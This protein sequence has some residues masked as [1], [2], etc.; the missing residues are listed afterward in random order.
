MET[1]MHC[2]PCKRASLRMRA[3]RALAKGMGRASA[4][5]FCNIDEKTLVEWIKRFN[6]MGI[7]GFVDKPR[8]GAPRKTTSSQMDG[9]VPPLPNNPAGAGQTHW[10]A[11]KLH[12]HITRELQR[13]VSRP[14]LVRNLHEKGYALKT[15]GPAPEPPD[16]GTWQR[17][18][19]SFKGNLLGWTAD[20]GMQ[21]WFCDESGFEGDP[22]PRKRWVERG[23]KPRIPY[24]GNHLRRNVIGAVSPGTGE[25]SAII[26]NHCDTGV[27]QAF[28][29][30]MAPEYPR[31]ENRRQVIV[32]DNA[33]WHKAR[34]LNRHH[35]EPEYLP[36]HCPDF[37]PMER[38][39]LGMKN[40][41][42]TDYYTK[43]GE[44]LEARIVTALRAFFDASDTVAQ[45]CTISG[46]F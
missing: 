10:T 3:L 16:V 29:D 42:F 12:G 18:R 19:E 32:P 7:D 2:C 8:R 20:D 27:F 15:P 45:T 28:P 43:S 9:D 21:P 37:N 1:A 25:P 4:A 44:E 14:T 26:L 23:G 34:R 6:P 35:S 38:F 46:N 33:S 41:Y 5:L 31:Q 22:G 30:N 39:W 17:Q 13:E 36:P 24:G 40:D 11:L